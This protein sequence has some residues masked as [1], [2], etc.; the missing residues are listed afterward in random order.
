MPMS[1][2]YHPTISSS[3]VPFSSFPQS[4]PASGSFPMRWLFASGGQSI[5]ASAWASDL[6]MNIQDWFPLGWTGWIFL[7]SKGLSRVFS[8]TTVQSINSSVLSPF[9]GPT[10]TS[11]HDSWKNHSFDCTGLCQQTRIQQGERMLPSR[12][13]HSVTLWMRG[14]V[15]WCVNTHPK[16]PP[17]KEQRHSDWRVSSAMIQEEVRK[18][19]RKRLLFNLIL[20]LQKLDKAIKSL[21]NCISHSA[22]LHHFPM[23][24]RGVFFPSCHPEWTQ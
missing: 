1:R 6:P 4:F 3:V 7:Q 22:K 5:G 10:L 18:Q 8:N 12:E 21:T 11:T 20:S 19:N 2:W 16:G 15:G 13:R 17:P 14:R 9:Y 24:P 23:P